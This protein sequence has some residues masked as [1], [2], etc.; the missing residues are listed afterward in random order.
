ML[1]LR[2][3][4]YQKTQTSYHMPLYV[5]AKR[6]NTTIILSK[7]QANICQLTRRHATIPKGWGSAT[8]EGIPHIVR[9]GVSSNHDY[10]H[11]LGILLLKRLYCT[12]FVAGQGWGVVIDRRA[13]MVSVPSLG[14]RDVHVLVVHAQWMFAVVGPRKQNIVFQPFEG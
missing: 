14:P 4:W 13:S 7:V 12:S 2:R 11:G 5:C 9:V 8:E 3:C 10:K 1:Y 6:K